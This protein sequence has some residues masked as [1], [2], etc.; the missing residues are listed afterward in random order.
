MPILFTLAST[1]AFALA[2]VIEAHISNQKLKKIPVMLFYI[3]TA[4]F[5]V[6]SLLFLTGKASVP[7]IEVL[8]ACFLWGC[9]DTFTLFFTYN[10]YKKTD[11]SIAN[12]LSALGKIP[13]AFLSYFFLGEVLCFSQYVGFG[14]IIVAA[15]VLSTN[16]ITK[17]K[18]NPAFW[19]VLTGASIR[20][21]SIIVSKYALNIDDSWINMTIYTNLFSS[22]AGF[23]LYLFPQ[24]RKDIVSAFPEYL[25]NFKILLLDEIVCLAGHICYFYSLERMNVLAQSAITSSGP[26]FTL[27]I[28]L[29]L[30]RFYKFSFNEKNAPQYVGKKLICFVFIISG[31]LMTVKP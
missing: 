29:F 14:V 24:N 15:V 25:Q 17:F 28:G 18:L 21:S 19:L 20:A 31:I 11:T 22:L 6:A 9:I 8:I 4:N 10:A 27:L 1:F 5:M 16:R 26:I 12:A 3:S 7:P 23:S 30:Q 13:M 2:H